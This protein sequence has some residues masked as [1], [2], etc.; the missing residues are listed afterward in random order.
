MVIVVALQLVAGCGGESRAGDDGIDRCDWPSWGHSHE[1]SFSYPC[2]TAISPR[3]VEDLEQAWFF[4][5]DDAV[6]ATPAVVDGTVY[7]GDWSGRFYALALDSGELVWSFA[8]EPHG[9]TYAGQIVSSAA[10]DDVDG[11]R[12][13]YFASGKTVYALR[14][15]DG[16]VRWQREFGREGDDND[17]TEIESSPVVA[18]GMVILGTDV[19]NSPGGEPTVVAAMDAATGARRWT[20][21]TA[22]TG[23]DDPT[24]PGCGDVWGSPSVDLD[25]KLVFVG[26]GNCI[27]A[28][29]WGDNSEALLA[30]DLDTGERRWTYQPHEQ[31]LD[32]L[33]FAGAPNLFEIGDRAVVGLGN[34]DAVYYAVDRETGEP[35]WQRKVTEPGLPEEGANYSFGG[36]IGPAAYAD[37]LI[38][39]GTAVGGSPHLHALDSSTGEIV[40]QQPEAGPT[41]AAA[42]EANGVVYIGGTDF[43]FRA[44][45]LR[46]GEVL[47]SHEMQGAVSGGAAIV[48][49]AVVAVAGTREPG[50]DEPSDNA[51]VY[52]FSLPG[53]GGAG[54]TDAPS[55]PSTTTGPDQPVAPIDPAALGQACVASPCALDFTLTAERVGGD[56]GSG[57]VQITADPFRVEV[58]AEG[59]GLPERWLRPGSAAARDGA[60]VYGVYLSQG[61]DN[62]V[63][64]LVCVLDAGDDCT[65]AEVP[66]AGATYDRISILAVDEAAELPSVTEGFD[67]MVTTNAFAVPFAPRPG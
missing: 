42:L 9:A 25:R 47:W 18:D 28:E 49:D 53:S 44:L 56:V 60:D 55:I 34:K 46:T 2:D 32:D 38:V 48:G 40:W 59:L 20:A 21:T 31:N 52:R 6:T 37:G 30:L 11:T 7:V 15:D 16:S 54:T 63:G 50:S 1:R 64:G 27:S 17:P 58:R 41:F 26:T 65:A 5:T 66:E 39:G 61:T 36:F 12:T 13:V 62:P 35:V 4:T 43:T 23:V 57:T 24:G 3:N 19:H 8:A 14:A 67:R 22:P 45:D 51:G 33:D 10:V 29:G